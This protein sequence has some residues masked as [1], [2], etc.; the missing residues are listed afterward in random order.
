MNFFEQAALPLDL[1]GCSRWSREDLERFQSRRLA[2]LVQHACE[3]VPFYRDLYRDHGIKPEDVR[4]LA[5]LPRLPVARREQMQLRPP[6]DLVAGG[7]DPR[8]LIEWRT[9]GSTGAPFTIRRT[10]LEDRLLN[11]VRIRQQWLRGLRWSDV[12]TWP[13]IG[14]AYPRKRAGG[15]SPWIPALRRVPV[16][17]L[18]EARE[19]LD[20]LAEAQPDV[21]VMYPGTLA[22][23]A[24]AATPADRGK[25]RPRLIFTGGEA[26]TPAM[27]RQISERFGAPVFD[28][29]GAHEFNLVSCECALTGL[30]HIE[31]TGVIVEVLK[32]GRPCAEGESGE[33]H[34][35]ALHSFAMPFLRYRLGDVAV[36]GPARCPCG[37]PNSTLLRIEGR[38]V[39]RFPLPHGGSLH[40]Y[41]LVIPLTREVNWVRRYQ[42]VQESLDRIR[43]RVV[44]I[45]SWGI[46]EHEKAMLCRRLEAAAGE[47]V[48]VALDLVEEIRPDPSGKLRSYYSEVSGKPKRQGGD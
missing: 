2:R 44:P 30:H 28:F 43:V 21:I 13:A 17:V 15:L 3:R 35:T 40:P 39:D 47:G 33:I 46:G 19:I 8:R 45:P 27:R 6:G 22:W 26:L 7:F 36:R 25:I 12:R 31:E 41:N 11:L 1:L 48:T 9:S 10:W 14:E 4:G 5:D 32:D 18:A 16:N 34:G 42:I 20:R 24:A 38:I 37:A 23:I 29:Y